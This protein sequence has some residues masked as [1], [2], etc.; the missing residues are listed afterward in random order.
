MR[1]IAPE[2]VSIVLQGA[3]PRGASP[4]PE[5]SSGVVAGLKACFPGAEIV[6]STW[7]GEHAE[8]LGADRVLLNEDPGEVPTA[9]SVPNNV[10][11]QWVS[12]VAGI[13]ASSRPYILKTRWDIG[14]ETDRLLV[15][16]DSPCPGG[17]HSD[18]RLVTPITT[19]NLFVR[20]AERHPMLYHPSDIV[21]FAARSSMTRFWCGQPPSEQDIYFPRPIPRFDKF[22]GGVFTFTP[23]QTLTLRWLREEGVPVDLPYPTFLNRCHLLRWERLLALNFA[24]LDWERSG[25]VFPPRFSGARRPIKSLHTEKDLA[26]YRARISRSGGVAAAGTCTHA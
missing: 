9:G 1:R 7:H 21:Q 12:T 5:A 26:D 6:V 22:R 19:T 24:V 8:G 17:A 20:K 16:D 18:R 2:E 25:V 3:L 4:T 23:E 11:R 15:I 10:L 13:E 14:F